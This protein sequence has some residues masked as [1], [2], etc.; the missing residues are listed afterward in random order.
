ML[1]L[2]LIAILAQTEQ[3]P[4]DLRSLILAPQARIGVTL[5]YQEERRHRRQLPGADGTSR[6][7]VKV[8]NKRFTQETVR[9]DADGLPDMV[10]RHYSEA[11]VTH[12]GKKQV[13]D[14]N[15]MFVMMEHVKKAEWN[16][17]AYVLKNGDRHDMP[18]RL[19]PV[20]QDAKLISAAPQIYAALEKSFPK[21]P[22]S[23][24]QSWPVDADILADAL[25]SLDGLDANTTKLMLSLTR[26]SETE[27]QMELKGPVTFS[28]DDSKKGNML[29]QG[30]VTGT[31]ILERGPY[32]ERLRQ[33]NVDETVTLSLDGKS[34]SA[35]GTQQ[36]I[37][38]LELDHK[39]P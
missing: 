10:L 35:K 9:A 36:L 34:I 21:Q 22:V 32:Q 29:W 17:S 19:E 12:N 14:H 28:A 26:V 37:R 18:V 16:V 24:G 3:A 1:S 30:Q 25:E 15:A 8:T 31:L 33:V 11:T 39:E 4:Y 5:P 27:V 13:Y 7:D 23:I 2:F 38:K 6:Q 20:R